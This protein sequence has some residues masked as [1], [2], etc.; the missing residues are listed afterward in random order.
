MCANLKPVPQA[1][2]PGQVNRRLPQKAWGVQCPLGW[3]PAKNYLSDRLSA[4]GLKNARPWPPEPGHQGASPKQQ[5]K[6]IG[7]KRHVKV[8]L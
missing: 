6:R 3:Q 8:P 2:A 1:Q 4:M 5:L 7:H